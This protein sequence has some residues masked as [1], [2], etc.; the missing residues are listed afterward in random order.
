MVLQ[1]LEQLRREEKD[2]QR[3]DEAERQRQE[4]EHI[5]LQENERIEA[6]RIRLQNKRKEDERRRQVRI[7]TDYVLHESGVLKGL[8]D[9]QKEEL[10]GTVRKQA[11]VVNKDTGTAELVWGRFSVEGNTVVHEKP[12]LGEKV[13]D[14]QSVEVRVDP[15]TMDL[16]IEGDSSIRLSKQ[17]WQKNP[18]SVES[19]L[20]KAYFKPNRVQDRPSDHYTSS[21]Y[22]S[23]S[24]DIGREC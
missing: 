18:H 22:S 12:L 17:E 14:Y 11:L 7:N 4:R 1:H 6:E 21:S 16:T 20:A 10:Q 24:G 3:R 13:K 23:S 9:L 2:R 19:A 8:E 5:R 15:D